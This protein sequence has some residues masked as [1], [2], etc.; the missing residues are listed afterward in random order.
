VG[1]RGR[2]A[3]ESLLAVG[4]QERHGGEERRGEERRGEKG[5][6][7][8]YCVS[9]GAIEKGK[10]GERKAGEGGASR[11]VGKRKESEEDVAV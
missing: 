11:R 8:V 2:T 7:V 10:Q 9:G 5:W 4:Q 6:T 3:P 1:K